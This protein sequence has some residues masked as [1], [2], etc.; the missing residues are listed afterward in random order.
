M[1][2]NNL[3][4]IIKKKGMIYFLDNIDELD[5]YIYELKELHTVRSS[6]AYKTVYYTLLELL[7][8]L[9]EEDCETLEYDIKLLESRFFD[10]VKI[11][12]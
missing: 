2:L 6:T 9:Q 8:L 5:F 1:L 12:K 7:E 10:Y 3:K 4:N 11:I